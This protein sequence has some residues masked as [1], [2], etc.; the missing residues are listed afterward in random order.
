MDLRIN[1][2]WLKLQNY[3]PANRRECPFGQKQ[4]TAK[5]ANAGGPP[6]YLV[7]AGLGSA[8]AIRASVSVSE[9]RH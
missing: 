7:G 2:G 5:M 4:N 6:V 9:I 1:R 3:Q 8:Q